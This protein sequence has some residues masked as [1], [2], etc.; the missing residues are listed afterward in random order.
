M[1]GEIG[2]PQG[3]R[4]GRIFLGHKKEGGKDKELR[5]MFI[6]QMAL[7]RVQGGVEEGE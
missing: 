2:L 7:L 4:T 1:R 5:N 6:R 3:G